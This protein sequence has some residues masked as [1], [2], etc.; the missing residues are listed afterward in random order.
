MSGKH[1]R[2]G[3]YNPAWPMDWPTPAAV[4]TIGG[5]NIGASAITFDDI[6]LTLDGAGWVAEADDSGRTWRGM[7]D[8]SAGAILALLADRIGLRAEVTFKP[9]PEGGG[10]VD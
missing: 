4:L 7:S 5:G 3:S 2:D 6:R 10:D 1:F 9:E 8:S